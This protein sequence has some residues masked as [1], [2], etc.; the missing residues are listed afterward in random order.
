MADPGQHSEVEGWWN[1]M[2]AT[3]ETLFGILFFSI[4][5]GLVVEV[6]KDKMEML[7]KGKTAVVE[8][9]HTIMLGW[10]DKSLHFIKELILANASEGGGVI[11]VLSEVSWR[12]TIGG[13]FAA[14]LGCCSVGLVP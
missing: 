10:T 2:I 11:A 14:R 8:I 12:V 4:V 6:V 1:R 3:Y 5:V 7:R 13:E 9:N